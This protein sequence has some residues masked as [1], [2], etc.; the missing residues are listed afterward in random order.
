MPKKQD[1]RLKKLTGFLLYASQPQRDQELRY[2][3]VR[4][5]MDVLKKIGYEKKLVIRPHPKEKNDSIYFKASTETGF[6]NFLIDRTT[7]LQTHFELCDI[8][9]VAFST[10]GTEFISQMKPMIVFDYNRQD[11]MGWIHNK[12]GI[13]VYEKADLEKILRKNSL[14]VVKSI[15]ESYIQNFYLTDKSTISNLKESIGAN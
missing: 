9:L 10:V 2:Q 12:V 4:D 8:L 14:T 15:N 7:D 11:L 5:I 3:T 1:V 6:D 13:P